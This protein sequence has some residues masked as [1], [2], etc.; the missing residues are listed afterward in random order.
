MSVVLYILLALVA[1]FIILIS[2]IT[3]SPLR[4][5]ATLNNDGYLIEIKYIGYWRNITKGQRRSGFLWFE[6]KRNEPQVVDKKQDKVAPESK[7]E[8][9]STPPL[10]WWFGKRQLF[11][12]C[13]SISARLIYEVLSSFNFKIETANLCIC[14][15]EDP[16]LA[17]MLYGWLCS[18]KAT[19]KYLDRLEIGYNFSPNAEW[20][21][22][23]HFMFKNC[24]FKL[25]LAPLAKALWRLPKL[26]I[27]RAYC[28]YKKFQPA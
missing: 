20:K 21:F 24:I 23:L 14:G 9:K 26:E 10:K 8:K 5:Y 6:F 11:T 2:I 25:I 3:F 7:G 18:L 27:Y 16:A 13:I 1:L 22:D 15:D 19:V 28:E 12:K 17:G 4:L